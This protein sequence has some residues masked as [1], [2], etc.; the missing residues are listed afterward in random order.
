MRRG[1]LILIICFSSLF[2]SSQQR[3]D[4]L[5]SIHQNNKSRDS[6][7]VT[8]LNNL[9]REYLNSNHELAQTL[10][11]EALKL[12]DSIEYQ[13][14]KVWAT[15]NRGNIFW[16][17]GMYDAALNSY[18]R[19]VQLT[20]EDMALP[21][22]ALYNNIGEV[23]KRKNQFDSALVYL[24]LARDIAQRDLPEQE[25]LLLYNIGELYLKTQNLPQAEAYI[26]ASVKK[27]S[28]TTTPRHKAYAWFGKGELASKQG[29]LSEAIIFHLRSYEIRKQNQDIAGQ[30]NSLNRL[31][32]LHI[33]FTNVQK[34]NQ[35]ISR[36]L[37]LADSIKNKNFISQTYL[38]KSNLLNATG[39]HKEANEWLMRH[40]SMKD[41]VDQMDFTD[42]VD[43]IKST[44][45]AEIKEKNFE[46]LEEKQLLQ[47]EVIKRQTWIIISVSILAIVLLVFFMNYRENLRRE[48]EHSDSLNDLNSVILTKNQKIEQIN[49]SLDH[50]LIHATKLL[51]ES[52]KISKID[53]WEYNFES[54]S[55]QWTGD[56]FDELGM[57]D[58][59]EHP[60]NPLI[61]GYITR[62]SYDR[63]ADR[64]KSSTKEGLI[65]EEDVKIEQEEGKHRFFRF[66]Y[67]VDRSD[68]QSI[69]AYGS[70]QEV[71]DLVKTEEK[72]KAIISSLFDLSRSANLSLVTYDFEQFIEHLLKE[73]SE[74]ME[75]LG[76]IFWTYDESHGTLKCL[77]AYGVSGV[78]PGIELGMQKYPK[79]FQRL[80]DYRSTPVTDLSKDEI[81]T[82]LNA[83][84]YQNLGVKSLLDSNVE[85]EG[86]LV[87]LF[88]V[89]HNGPKTWSY[90]DQRYVGSLTDIISSA[91]ST[92][93][94][95]QL[96][97][98]KGDLIKT[99]LKRNE[100][101]EELTY[102]ITH[103]LRG[104]LTR[105]I[106]LSQLYSDPQSKGIE[107]EI[108]NRINKSSI[109]LDQ[110]I[111]DLIEIIKYSDEETSMEEIPL[112]EIVTETLTE[113][114][115]E[116]PAIQTDTKISIHKNIKVYGN[117]SQVK[118]IMYAL[119]SNAF[120]FRRIDKSLEIR[121]DARRAAGMIQVAVADNGRGIDL[122]KFDQKIF[123]MYQRFH[124]DIP[125]TGIGLFIVK[126]LIEAMG[127]H[128]DVSSK[129]MDG[130]VFT[131]ALPDHAPMSI[132]K[133]NL[134]A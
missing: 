104:P 42:Q 61:M 129:P 84:F 28:A 38:V 7:Y 92:N 98:E 44:L 8:A 54:G 77:K 24:N 119:I 80:M 102:V 105:I 41:S 126:N 95:K 115:A 19:A 90:S 121:I 91:Y 122:T 75:V 111:K 3:I 22:L 16:F 29:E 10:N 46:L 66:R 51:Y 118:N 1:L 103:H 34:A 134:T 14:G 112:K 89:V 109:E 67:F 56:R 94:K 25:V 123:K 11:L 133:M 17:A 35:L 106:G 30:I 43:R 107:E 64:L 116:W 45:N 5:I 12:A 69:R 68:D 73:S 59:L 57:T 78:E 71:T 39:Q 82:L 93:L 2:V 31:A 4:S 100:N 110:V 131:V 9:T 88:S 128:I 76:A 26:S 132:S 63:V 96:E 83:Y 120:K 36:S 15:V 47:N 117:T 65:F 27:I 48:K 97:R 62:Q 6:S 130:T 33:K 37:T 87:G 49:A 72:E 127:G 86:E 20:E 32:E 81:T 40:F 114:G 21:K 18:L 60:V 79:Y 58:N 13:T 113:V 53:S 108:I 52:Q 99:L 124:V 101:L 85:I 70:S 55:V 50:K 23:F 74:I 125:G